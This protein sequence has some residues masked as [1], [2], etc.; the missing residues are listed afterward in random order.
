MLD[1]TAHSSE[2]A[3]TEALKTIEAKDADGS[4]WKLPDAERTALYQK[5]Y[6]GSPSPSRV[7]V[8]GAE[9]STPASQSPSPAGES[10]APW[11]PPADVAKKMDAWT[12]QKYGE[13]ELARRRALPGADTTP[14]LTVGATT[15]TVAPQEGEQA[16]V[17]TDALPALTLPQ[18]VAEDDPAVK[19]VREIGVYAEVP[20]KA[21]ENLV[22]HVAGLL[23]ADAPEDEAEFTRQSDAAISAAQ[24]KYGSHYAAFTQAVGLGLAF[25]RGHDPTLAELLEDPRLQNSLPVAEALAHVGSRGRSVYVRKYGTKRVA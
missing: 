7:A 19:S 9:A 4:L 1:V 11:P 8:T 13:A 23:E 3:S 24:A 10:P 25:V 20:P 2:H 5:A 6:P 17:S 16:P 12:A 14:L 22:G 18:G 21:L 15:E